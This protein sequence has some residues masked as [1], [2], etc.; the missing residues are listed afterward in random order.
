MSALTITHT[1]ADGTLIDGTAR[2]DGSAQILKAQRWRWSRNLGSWYLP[3][4]RDRR[5]KRTQID[6]TAT[7]LRTA[8]FTV[9]VDIGDTY[10]PTADVESDKIARQAARVDALDAKADRKAGTA[11]AAWAADQ[12]AHDALPEGGEPIKV[13]HHSETRHRRAVEKSWNALSKAVAA[14]REAATARGRVDAAAKT[15]DRRYAPVTVARRID[16]LTAELRRLERDRDGYTRTLHTNKQTGQKYVETH[17][18]ASGDYRERILAEIEHTADE[19]VYWKGVRAH[20]IA[21]GTATAYSRDVVAVGDVVRYVGHFHRVLKVN[22]KT[23][24]IGSIVGGSW[25]DRVP[26][27]EIRGLRDGQGRPVRID[28]GARVVDT[29]ADTGPDAA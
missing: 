20:Q 4:S 3:Q 26:Y 2:G 15:T 23:V 10:R 19:L 13:G 8:G 1:H 6:A 14:E 16:K 29:D 22:A 21:A 11:E 5:A 18:A 24:T 17:E 25:T 7:A 28:D 12:A 9:E 27:T